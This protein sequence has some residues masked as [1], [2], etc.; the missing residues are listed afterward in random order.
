M[1]DRELL[2]EPSEVMN[3]DKLRSFRE[4]HLK[5]KF[6]PQAQQKKS[7]IEIEHGERAERGD[8][9]KQEA[10]EEEEQEVEQESME[11]E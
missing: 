2:V 1:A 9:E 11:S 6:S 8:S 4:E 10:Q 5:R 7:R 3:A